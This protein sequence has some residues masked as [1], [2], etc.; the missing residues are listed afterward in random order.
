MAAVLLSSDLLH[1][2]EMGVMPVGSK[3]HLGYLQ[4]APELLFCVKS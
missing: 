4:E 1:W 2:P 3:N